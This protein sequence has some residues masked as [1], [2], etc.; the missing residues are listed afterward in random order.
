MRELLDYMKRNGMSLADMFD[1]DTLLKMQSDIA[2]RSDNSKPFV[3]AQREID[4]AFLVWNSN[5]H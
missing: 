5:D 1:A 2:E 3:I 4:D